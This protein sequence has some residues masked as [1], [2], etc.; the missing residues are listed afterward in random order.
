MPVEKLNDL[1]TRQFV[2]GSQSM[3]ARLELSKGCKVPTHSH[4]NEQITFVASGALLFQLGAED[5][6]EE[7]LVRA[8]E[9][10]VIPGG[11]PHSAVAVEDTVDFDVFAPPREDWIRRDDSYL[12]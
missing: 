1:L 12:R 2:H 5:A 10:L 9:L 11:L 7:K 4:P 6:P 8:G 3:L